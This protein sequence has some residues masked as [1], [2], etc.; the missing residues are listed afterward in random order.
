V[1]GFLLTVQW[2]DRAHNITHN[3]IFVLNTSRIADTP[4]EMDPLDEEIAELKA[5]IKRYEAE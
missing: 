5:V 2:T 3:Q 4:E 1:S